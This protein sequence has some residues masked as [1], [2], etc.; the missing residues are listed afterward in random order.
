MQRGFTL[1]ELAIVLVIIGLLVGGGLVGQDLIKSAQINATVSDLQSYT[2]AAMTFRDKYGGIPGDLRAD[3]AQ[4]AGLT[5]YYWQPGS[6][7]TGDGDGNPAEWLR[8]PNGRGDRPE[9]A[10]AVRIRFSGG[11]FPMR[12]SSLSFR[13]QRAAPPTPPAGRPTPALRKLRCRAL[14][15]RCAFARPGS[16]HASGPQW[17]ELL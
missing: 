3:K 5:V 10:L 9:R 12:S 14:Y 17:Q 11:S 7:G 4:A 2:D 15:R 1:V 13:M 6:F 8:R 16:S